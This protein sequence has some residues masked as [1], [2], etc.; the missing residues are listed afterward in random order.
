MLLRGRNTVGYAPYPDVVCE[1]FVAEA[2][3]TGIDIFRVFDALNDVGQMSPAIRAAVD[4]GAVAEG[5]LCYSGNMADP[6]ETLYNLD[7]YLRIAEGLVEAGS[8]VLCVKDMAGLLRAPAARRLV[9]A[10]RNRFDL[11]VHL[12][13]H[14][15]TG[16][17]LATYLAAIDAGVDAIDGAAAPMS[18]MTS[19]PSLPAIVAATD[20]DDRATGLSLD[21]IND[22]EPYWEAVRRMYAPFEMGLAAPTGT[23]YR[24][25]IP[26]GQLSNL[27]QQAVALGI[28]DRFEDVER[29]Y[30]ACDRLLGRPIKVTPSSKVIGD[31]ALHLVAAGVSVETLAAEP[32]SVDLPDSVVGFLRGEL[33]TPEAGFPEPFRT[34]ALEG[35]TVVE[36]ASELSAS[37]VAALESPAV[38]ATLNRLLFPGPASSQAEISERYGDLSVLPTRLFLYGLEEGDDELA[39]G[40][41]QGVRVLV[42][43]EAIGE[44]NDEG[45]RLVVFRLNGQLRPI[46]AVD[47]A[48]ATTQP[49]SEQADPK[50]QGHIAAPFRGVAHVAV[51]VG[52]N[53]M[54]GQ[55]VA[56]IEAMKLDSSIST[57][58]D[59]TVERVVIGPATVVEPGDLL[60]EIRPT[61]TAT[62]RTGAD[63]AG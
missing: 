63:Q 26:G 59:G 19:Q 14:D 24:H 55:A 42:E 9:T 8:H 40:L 30:A 60:L 16:G 5:T 44:A 57:P 33:G 28:G 6:A 34:Q 37:Q 31:L 43:L 13:T 38:R 36:P 62:A 48:V 11:P 15:T 12:H 2:P 39:I 47:R 27:R 20:H 3:A 54:S 29:L 56:N 18:G 53:V 25:E 4:V 1:R 51:T 7:Y 35:R 41:E 23:V 46:E 22:L 50:N 52:Q 32:A 21:A 45:L 49:E 58:I 17:Q 61:G 10:L